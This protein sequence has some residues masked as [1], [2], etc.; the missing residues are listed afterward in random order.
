MR[1]RSDEPLAWHLETL[2]QTKYRVRVT[3]RPAAD[4]IDRAFDGTIVLADRA[5]LEEAVAPQMLVP[6]QQPERMLAHAIE[7]HLPPLVADEGRIGRRRQDREHGRA[8]RHLVDE[9]RA[10]HGVDV[11]GIT[12]IGRAERDDGLQGLGPAGGDL[13]SVETTPGDANHADRARAPFLLGEPGD[14]LEAVV[15]L[16][17]GILVVENAFAVTRAADVDAHARVAETGIVGMGDRVAIRGPIALAIGQI[18]EDRR[19]GVIFCIDRQPDLRSEPR[20]VL[21]GNEDVAHNFDLA[22]IVLADAH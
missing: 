11:V 5:V 12:I 21:Q 7:P 1:P 4:C 8:P 14:H 9:Q 15:L 17:F 19:N 16:L 13:Q 22:R 18:L 20:T 2:E 10:A 6:V 3:V